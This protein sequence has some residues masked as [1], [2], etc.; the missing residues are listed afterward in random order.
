MPRYVDAHSHLH[1]IRF[2]VRRD[3]ALAACERIGVV[4]NVV[5]GTS[6]HDWSA[7]TDLADRFKWIIP[8]Y[9]VHPWYVNSIQEGWLEKLKGCLLARPSA[10]GEIGIDHWKEGIDRE[11]QES[12]FIQQL[13]LA[14]ELNRPASIHGLKAWG[15]LLELLRA[16]GVPKAGFLLHSYSGPSELVAPFAELGAFFSCA[17]AFFAP[18]RV[19]K[20]EVFRKVP[21]DR[22]LPETDAPDQRL[23]EAPGVVELRGPDGQLLNH[24]TSI[25][26]VYRGFAA[27]LHLDDALLSETLERNFFTLFGVTVQR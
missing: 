27:L 4:A 13:K 11:I 7:V 2:G 6:C 25:S 24:P 10:V 22:I 14:S 26:D 21:I 1:D 5:N 16:H 3:E 18:S 12:V 15:R 19:K 20:L 17:P 23:P 8:S 9:G